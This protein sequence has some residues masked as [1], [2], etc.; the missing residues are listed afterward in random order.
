MNPEHLLKLVKE[1]LIGL[2]FECSEYSLHSTCS[3]SVALDTCL[4]SRVLCIM[5][6]LM[7]IWYSEELFAFWPLPGHQ[8][9]PLCA[10]SEDASLLLLLE[11]LQLQRSFGL[12]NEFLPFGLVS[13]AFL[14]V[15]Y[16][17]PCYVTL[18]TVLPSIFR[19]S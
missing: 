6:H 2:W 4:T 10:H 15:C 19:S 5:F 8:N 17:Q 16:F 14:P 7:L 12:L 9:H 11:A 3:F 1:F 18:Y 13:D